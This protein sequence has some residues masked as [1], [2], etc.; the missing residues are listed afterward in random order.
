MGAPAVEF[1]EVSFAYRGQT[2]ALSVLDRVSL[3]VSHG[4]WATLVGPSGCGK[5]TLLKIGA[6]LL[7]P[8]SGTVRV[9][10]GGDGPRI[11]YMPQADTLL[12]WRDALGN[13]LLPAEAT[14]RNR[15][16]ARAEAQA[17]FHEFGLAGFE[18]SYPHELSGG[19]R[20]R[21]ALMRTLLSRGE[22]LLLDEPFGALDALTRTALQ[23]WLAAARI[24]R[25][26][27]VLLVTHDVEEAVLLSDQVHVLSPRPARVVATLP[28]A[29]PHPRLRTDPRI[30][31]ARADILKNL[32]SHA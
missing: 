9:Q 32:A 11:A 6:R 22:V 13:A 18:R 16:Q 12:P 21:L 8:D 29:L 14:G 15:A 28:V 26:K 20:Q 27:T 4:G 24:F 5:T 19:M 31:Q 7:E 3:A 1:C 2:G 17:L 30:A 23:D 10:D 25:R